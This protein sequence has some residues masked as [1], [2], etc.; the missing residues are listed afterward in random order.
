M[1]IFEEIKKAR[2]MVW[3]I[4]DCDF[5]VFQRAEMNKFID[6]VLLRSSIEISMLRKTIEIMQVEE[7]AGY[8]CEECG[9]RPNRVSRAS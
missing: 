8:P 7:D 4:K 6:E 3:D 5:S 1:T 9:F 2:K